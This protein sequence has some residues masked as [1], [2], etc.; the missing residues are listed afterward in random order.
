[1]FDLGRVS[2]ETKGQPFSVELADDEERT[3]V[4]GQIYPL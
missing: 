3:E 1:M 4:P 2:E